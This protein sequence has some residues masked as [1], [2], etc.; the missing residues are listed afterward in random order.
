MYIHKCIYKH[1]Y[2]YINCILCVYI[3]KYVYMYLRSSLYMYI[4]LVNVFQ[5][6][7]MRWNVPLWQL[8]E[9]WI[10]ALAEIGKL[11]FQLLA[12]VDILPVTEKVEGEEG[13]TAIYE[14]IKKKI[15]VHRKAESY[16]LLCTICSNS[17]D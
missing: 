16:Y 3:Y 2:L 8:I 11:C 1:I 17:V 7:F 13:R 5:T 10:P 6:Y 4:C 14:K 9:V 15:R 12:P